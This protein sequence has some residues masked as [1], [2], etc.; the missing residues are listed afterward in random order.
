[1]LTVCWTTHNPHGLSD[2]DI[3]MAKYS[4]EQAECL[5]AVAADKAIRCG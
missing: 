5:G 1:M 4:D 3:L 2:K